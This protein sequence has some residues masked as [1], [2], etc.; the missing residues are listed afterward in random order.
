MKA[1]GKRKIAYVI[2]STSILPLLLLG[3]IILLLGT[4]IFKKA[5][6][7]EV[8]ADLGNVC[9]NLVTFFDTLY[10][11]DYRLEE[12]A[13]GGCRLY[14]GS[15]D[16]T[17]D[18]DLID[19]IKENTGLDITLFFQDTRI[20]TTVMDNE[21]KRIV[22]TGA[23]PNVMEDVFAAGKAK[24]YTQVFVFNT[25]YFA[26]YIPLV[27]SSGNVTGMF[28]VGKPTADVD[29]SIQSAIYPLIIADVIFMIL[30]SFIIFLYT[31]SFTSSLLQIHRF[32]REVSAGNLNA[33]LSSEALDRRDELGEIAHSVVNMQHSLHSLIEQDSLTALA[34]RRCGDQRL[35]QVVHNASA[36]GKDFCIAIGDIDDFKKVNDTY[37]HDCG[38]LVLKQV[39]E[40]LR[41]HMC[42][43]GFAARWGGEEF[44]LVFEN[45][46]LESARNFLN[47]ILDDIRSMK[48]RYDDL[49]VSVTMTFGLTQG[50]TDNVTELLRTADERLY[51]GKNSGKNQVV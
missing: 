10:P 23:A 7:H 40:I 13:G 14:K 48:C 50:N 1:T 35:K 9:R 47:E 38:D 6:Y 43:K 5:M 41:R 36:N 8:E 22:G 49:C 34:N 44:L 28:F 29:D 37:G 17:A 4:Q 42:G 39:A 20:L 51:K 45:L 3:I 19:Q 33:S 32:L 26:Y 27:N 12:E 24:F 46:D 21:G 2:Q 15:H 16:L 30:V 11:G 31:R 18:F 25:D